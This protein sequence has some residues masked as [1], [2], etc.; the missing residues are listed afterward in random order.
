[1]ATGVFLGLVLGVGFALLKEM[2]DDPI[3][4]A[5]DIETQMGLSVLGVIPRRRGGSRLQIARESALRTNNLV[6]EAFAGVRAILRSPQYRQ[7]SRSLLVTSTAPGEGKT[8]VASNLAISCARHGDKTLLVDFD[9][10]RPQ[11]QGIFPDA[12][13]EGRGLASAL[14]AGDFDES[15]FASLVA[16][17]EFE[18]LDVAA[19]RPVEGGEGA[20]EVVGGNAARAFMEWAKKNYDQVVV[21]SP[22]LGLISDAVVLAEQT[23]GVLMVCWADR[24]RKHTVMHAI[25]HLRDIGANVVGAIVNSVSGDVGGGFSRYDCYHKEYSSGRYS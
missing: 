6:A 3:T 1:M 19:S 20:T 15:R 8:I 17:T 18:N 5:Q 4:S 14:I 10:R 25:G 22:P 2:L 21:D 13:M 9:L 7:T 11:I 16:S 23:T 24:S 12:K